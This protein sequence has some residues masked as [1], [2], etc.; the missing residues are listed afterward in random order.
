MRNRGY[1]DAVRLAVTFGAFGLILWWVGPRQLVAAFADVAW[2]WVIVRIVPYAASLWVQ[3]WRWK[4]FLGLEGITTDTVRLFRR[5]WMSR[6]FANM[7]PGSIGGDIF[8]VVESGDFSNSRMSVARSVLLDRVVALVSLAAYTSVACLAWAWWSDWP[9]LARAAGIGLLASTAVLL[10]LAT[11]WPSRLTHEVG[12]RL[13]VAAAQAFAS[14]LA[15]SLL[16][17]A[18]RRKLLVS[19]ALITILFNV[20]WAIGSYCGFLAFDLTISPLLVITLIPVVYAATALPISINGLGVSEGVFVLVFAAAGLQPAD[21][22]AVA[23]LLRVTGML[24]SG[25]GGL[26]YLIE[27]RRMGEVRAS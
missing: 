9:N 26:L 18:G 25:F 22:A 16:D 14:R 6:F 23:I 4:I 3:A 13:P 5:V 19:A 1:A 2:F 20:T 8:R 10:L 15:D 11:R 12:D 7:L 21:A 24:M 17:L 27:R